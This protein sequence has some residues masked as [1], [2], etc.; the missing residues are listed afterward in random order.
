MS[1]F[2]EMFSASS[3]DVVAPDTSIE[4]P[5]EGIDADLWLARLRAPTTERKLAFFG[6]VQMVF[7]FISVVWLTLVH[8]TRTYITT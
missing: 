3:L 7:L 6:N 8:Q 2:Q 5:G 4:F 1:T